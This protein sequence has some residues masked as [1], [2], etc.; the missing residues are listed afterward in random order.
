MKKVFKILFVVFIFLA[1]FS[2]YAVHEVKTVFNELVNDLVNERT[3]NPINMELL[4]E[5]IEGMEIKFEKEDR[6][7]VET[8]KTIYPKA[9]EELDKLYGGNSDELTVLMY[10]NEEDFHTASS[11]EKLSGYYLPLNDSMHLMSET[12]IPGYKFEDLFNH[13]YAHYRTDRFLEEHGIS[14]ESLPTW[15]NEG[16]SGLIQY[17]NTEVDID[18]VEKVEFEDLITNTSFH[19]ERDGNADPYLQSY[20]AVKELVDQFGMAV[21]PEILVALKDM[22]LEEALNKIVGM[23]SANLL[24]SYLEKRDVIT[25]LLN[26]AEEYQVNGDYKMVQH[27]YEEVLRLEPNNLSVSRTMP[28]ILVKQSKLSETMTMLKSKEELEVYDLQMLAEISLLSD[29][30]ES[31]KYTEMSEERIRKN[32]SDSTFTSPFGDAIRQNLSDPVK[33]Y[34]EIINKDLIMYEEIVVQLKVNL[35]E[36]YPD[37]RRVQNL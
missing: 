24:S 16:I 9:K 29:L 19:K 28:H 8:I 11:S 17:R 1:L 27:I 6:G 22:D 21:I 12:L 3:L 5:N 2:V 25:E 33:G 15:F 35:K 37:D 4:T 23:S 7:S 13:E 34:L 20:F 36:M 32:I 30:K 31:L 26:Q 18:L 10:A 14:V